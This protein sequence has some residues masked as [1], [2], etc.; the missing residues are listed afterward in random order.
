MSSAAPTFYARESLQVEVYDALNT[1]I[2]GGDDVSFFAELARRSVAPTLELGCG[3]GRITVPL[4]ESG[5]RIVGVDS[6]RAML[7]RAEAR[8]AA[9]APDARSRL[10]LVEAEM[11]TLALPYTFGLVFAA[12]RVFMSLRDPGAQRAALARI[13]SHLTPRGLLV[14]DVFDPLLDRFTPGRRPG[15]EV[16]VRH[17]KTGNMVRIIGAGR[18][19]DPVHQRFTEEFTFREIDSSGQVLREE[20]DTMSLRWTYRQELHHLLELANFDVEGEI[21][22]YAS[23]PPAY[24]GEIIVLARRREP[25]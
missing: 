18:I 12:F 9:L 19:N 11:T 3:T 23:S 5:I 7:V 16:E 20:V 6:S 15:R 17:P 1:D 25:R 4:A 21:S 13:W 8:R 2:P 24:G 22:D 14:I 10:Q